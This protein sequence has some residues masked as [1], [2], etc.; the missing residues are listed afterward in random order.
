KTVRK[1]TSRPALNFGWPRS[2]P[3]RA[4]SHG[5]PLICSS[6]RAILARI[7]RTGQTTPKP[8]CHAAPGFRRLGCGG[9]SALD[10]R[11]LPRVLPEPAAGCDLGPFIGRALV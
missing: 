4:R 5:A 2:Q 1:E 6:K 9:R 3:V 11:L 8:R 7:P 10:R